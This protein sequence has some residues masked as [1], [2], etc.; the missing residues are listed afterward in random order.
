MASERTYAI[1]KVLA[2]ILDIPYMQLVRAEPFLSPVWTL[3]MAEAYSYIERD[4]W[5]QF[6]ILIQFLTFG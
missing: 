6:K 3:F 1:I 5:L 2:R 4:Q